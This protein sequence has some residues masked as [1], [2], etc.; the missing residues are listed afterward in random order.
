MPILFR[1]IYT[2]LLTVL[3][4]SAFFSCVDE[5]ES[6][7]D[8][9]G[10]FEALWRIMDE[11]YCFFTEKNIDWNAVHDKYSQQINAGMNR[12][13][14]FEVLANMLGELKDGHVNMYTAFDMARNWTWKENYPSNFSDTLLTKYLGR[15]Y[16]MAAGLKYRILDDNIGYI[17]CGSFSTGIGNGN[18]DEVLMYLAPTR[19]LIIDV[20]NNGGGN[21]LTAEKFAARFT[22]KEILVGYMQHK[23]GKGHDDFSSLEKQ[24]LKPGNGLRWQKSVVVLTNRGVF[25]AANEFVKYMRC[26]PLTTVVGDRTGGGGGLP[27][28]S[29]LPNGW[30]VRFSAC[31]MYDKNKKSVENGIKP[32]HPVELERSD[33]LKGQDTIIEYAR[34]LIQ[35]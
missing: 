3:C 11:H 12:M 28:T 2:L 22:N 17:Y 34:Q 7:N 29:E 32:D 26:C 19:G 23:T 9:K 15:D 8:P 6:A 5:E 21:L 33:L 20:R 10:N 1:K 27:F 18:L 35:Q 31:P 16:R 24:R 13:Q 25:S 4:L 14:L 30:T